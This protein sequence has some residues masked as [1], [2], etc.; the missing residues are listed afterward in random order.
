MVQGL[1]D[2]TDRIAP[3]ATMRRYL[4]EGLAEATASA[5]QLAAF[6]GTLTGTVFLAGRYVFAPIGCSAINASERSCENYDLVQQAVIGLGVGIG[7]TFFTGIV[8]G[9]ISDCIKDH[10]RNYEDWRANELRAQGRYY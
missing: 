6:A 4:L 2:F 7:V 8:V 5:V 3:R 9:S 1:H 10:R